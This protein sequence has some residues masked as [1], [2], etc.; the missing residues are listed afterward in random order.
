MELGEY[1]AASRS[2]SGTAVRVYRVAVLLE[3]GAAIVA[4]KNRKTDAHRVLEYI[5]TSETAGRLEVCERTARQWADEGRIPC[6]R[7]S[8]NRRR[9]PKA[10]IE[11]LAAAKRAAP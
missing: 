9:Y 1:Q 8:K 7:D 10:V 11:K 2:S 3:I 4:K 6:V 5:S